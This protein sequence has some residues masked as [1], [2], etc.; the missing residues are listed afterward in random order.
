M[1]KKTGFTLLLGLL[2][3]F[4]W[5]QGVPEIKQDV[6]EFLRPKLN[7]QRIEYF[8]GSYG[9]ETLPIVSSPFGESRI[10]NL[11][12]I[13]DGQKIMRTLAVVEFQQ[14]VHESLK[15]AHDA[16]SQ[17]QSIGIALQKSGWTIDIVPVYFGS[18]S[19]SSQ[20]K[21]WMQADGYD[22]A[23]VHI[24]KLHVFRN[25]SEDRLHYCTIIEVHSPL[26]L[27]E[28]WLQSLYPDQYQ[29]HRKKSSE[30]DALLK[31][32]TTL[33]HEFPKPLGNNIPSD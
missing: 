28:N 12:S 31:S 11:Y 5:I 25:P 16:I 6:V 8:F 19:L 2:L 13:H 27:D 20:L 9:V 32:L 21:A 1:I 24:Y 33:I 18:V 3:P 23:A 15:Q 29:D 4:R 14:P 22:Q 7:S 10:A 17:G 26:Y 30:I